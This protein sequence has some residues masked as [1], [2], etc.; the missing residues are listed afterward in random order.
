MV[1]AQA[2]HN[3]NISLE[4]LLYVNTRWY[5]FLRGRTL[6][7]TIPSL[8]T[9]GD[10]LHPR[11]IAGDILETFHIYKCRGTDWWHPHTWFVPP[12]LLCSMFCGFSSTTVQGIPNINRWILHIGVRAFL[13]FQYSSQHSGRYDRYYPHLSNI[14]RVPLHLNI[15]KCILWHNLFFP[16]RTCQCART[17]YGLNSQHKMLNRTV[18]FSWYDFF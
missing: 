6:H 4:F 3:G 8:S 13:L 17:N 9:Q 7:F 12:V 18:R 10:S 16:S 2:E 1:S 11:T 15:T 5:S 14:E